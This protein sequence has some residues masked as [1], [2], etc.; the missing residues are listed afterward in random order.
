MREIRL[1]WL[2]LGE[3][4]SSI[5]MS[6]IWPLTTI[7][8]HNHLGISLTQVGVILLF[9]SL[10][11]VLGSIIGGRLFDRLNPFYLIIGSVTLSF[12][13]ML[14]LIFNYGWPAFPIALLS[15]GF[16][17]GWSLTMVNSLGTTIHS[18]DGRYIFNMLYFAQNLGIVAG[19]AMVGFV[20]SV[21]ITLLFSIA[22]SLF[23]AFLVVILTTYHV[24]AVMHREVQTKTTHHV[25]LPKA[26][27]YIMGSFFFSLVIIW[28]MYEQ[29]NS[30]LSVYMTGMGILMR[31]YSLLWTINA[32]LIVVFQALLNWLAN[33]FTN[34]Y[35]QVY[36]GIFFVALSFVTRI[37][38]KDYAHFVIAM[39]I[40]TMG[41]AT[42]FP[43]I[44]AIVNSLTPAVVKGQYQGMA[45]AWA[46]VG[47]AFGPLFGGLVIDFGSYT[48][49]F[50]VAAVANLLVLG[51]NLVVITGNRRQAEVY[52]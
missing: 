4:F 49:L 36:A 41:E 24:P 23:G 35:L 48:L 14:V 11:N 3:L 52:K 10:A 20:Y 51:L 7:Y 46:S 12:V 33:F 16:A 31:D 42:A 27:R 5:G 43:A 40:L 2:L 37:F 50:V 9:Y 19:T 39:V 22:T 25:T 8:L 47:R 13:T 45:N 1:R 30:N 28:I 15:L 17:S 6:F 34:L 38:A 44:P 21:S 18:R 26:N 32:A 29:W